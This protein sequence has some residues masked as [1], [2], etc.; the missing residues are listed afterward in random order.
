MTIRCSS[1]E[2]LPLGFK[3]SDTR[4][5]IDVTQRC[6]ISIFFQYYMINIYFLFRLTRSQKRAMKRPGARVSPRIRSS[7][8]R[9]YSA[10][11]ST[12]STRSSAQVWSVFHMP[13]RSVAL[14]WLF[15]SFRSSASSPTSPCACWSPPP[16]KW[17]SRLTR[18][19]STPLSVDS[20][21]LYSFS[22]SS[23]IRSF[24]NKNL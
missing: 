7:P 19:L 12:S 18:S 24:V 10:L 2:Y 16:R 4:A 6:H 20:A 13:C 9:A 23:Y 14:P 8:T 3:G 22:C 1:N 15:F 21:T 17:A 11:V 5:N